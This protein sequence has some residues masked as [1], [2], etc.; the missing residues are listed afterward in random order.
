MKRLLVFLAALVVAATQL[1]VSPARSDAAPSCSASVAQSTPVPQAARHVVVLVHGWDGAPGN[2]GLAGSPAST[3]GYLAQQLGTT[4][5]FLRFSYQDVDAQWAADPRISQCLASYLVRAAS[6]SA[7]HKV[8]VVA[9]SMGGIATLFAMTDGPQASAARRA[10]AGMVTLSTPYTGSPWGDTAAASF[11]SAAT[12]HGSLLDVI[13]AITD[14]TPAAVLWQSDPLP[15][16]ARC[17]APPSR[18]PRDC[19]RVPPVPNG[20]PVAAY[21]GRAQIER[22]FFGHV[23]ATEDVGGDGI[24]PLDSATIGA[25]EV[26]GAGE[27]YTT[28]CTMSPSALQAEASELGLDVDVIDYWLGE[29][30]GGGDFGTLLGADTI[31]PDPSALYNGL[32]S[33]LTPCSHT[34]IIHDSDVLVHAAH[35]IG[36]MTQLAQSPTPLTISQQKVPDLGVPYFDTSG[37]YPVVSASGNDLTKVNAALSGALANDEGAWRR[38]VESNPPSAPQSA[39]GPGVYDVGFDPSYAVA[40]SALVSTMYPKTNLYPGGNDG[41]GWIDTTVLVPSGR[42]VTL[43]DLLGPNAYR[44]VAR[45]TRAEVERIRYCLPDTTG[46][47]A[48]TYQRFFLKG[49]APNANNYRYFA[50]SPV[51][52]DIGLQQGQIGIEACGT[53]RITLTWA[54]LRGSL[55]VNGHRYAHWATQG[56]ST[57]P[58]NE[59][60]L[61]DAA[62]QREHINPDDAGYASPDFGP[63]T[64]SAT[65]RNGWALAGVER[66][67]VGATDGTTLFK[68]VGSHW[69]EVGNLGGDPLTWCRLTADGVPLTTAKE[70]VPYVDTNAS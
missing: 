49:L 22:T 17:L 55:T 1:V 16:G 63:T 2:W 30:T 7:D 67:Y 24:V 43:Q 44:V 59:T 35:Q 4:Y 36:L 19:A 61:F 38:A 3:D 32:L 29:L 15:S 51:G 40:N 41:G 18:Q 27:S 6:A 68:A 23:V 13:H 39:S 5:T 42:A 20:M 21:G 66:P 53:R 12:L 47:F 28:T 33:L 48:S 69:Q 56:L 65:C 46:D 64:D 26:D 34:Q 14:H 25:R 8:V 54:S 57:A 11:I 37:T 31:T 10:V 62:A 60:A 58:C 9:H 50:L 70:L 45:K 52:L